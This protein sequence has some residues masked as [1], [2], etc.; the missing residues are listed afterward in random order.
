[1]TLAGLTG[2]L[3]TNIED[4][5]TFGPSFPMRHIAGWLGRTRYKVHVPHFGAVVIRPGTSDASVVRQ[6]FAQREYDLRK[7]AR[8]ESILAFYKDI[9]DQGRVP[10]IIDAGAN[11]G[12]AARLFCS[13]FPKAHIVAGEP[14]PDNADVCRANCSCFPAIDIVEAAIGSRPG[15]ADIT[16]PEADSWA[17]QTERVA[18]HSG[19]IPIRTIPDLVSSFGRRQLFIV[20]IDIEGFE[21]DLFESNLDW[22]DKSKVVMIEPHDWLFPGQATSLTFQKAMAARC[23]ELTIRGENLIYVRAD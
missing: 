16:D 8:W 14:D 21:N 11:I 23:F 13:V 20:K 7:N 4:A 19:G 22:L 6:V 9:V 1:M 3:K 12:M 15:F 2:K 18:A 10:V 5:L 17:F